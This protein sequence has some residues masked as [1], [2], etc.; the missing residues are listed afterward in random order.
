MR[1]KTTIVAALALLLASTAAAQTRPVLALYD[2][3]SD[4]ETFCAF[5]PT[6]VTPTANL[7][8]TAASATVTG[9]GAGTP[10][11]NVAVNDQLLIGFGTTNAMVRT[12]IARASASSI[13]VDSVSTFTSPST[14]T[15]F[16]YRNLRCSTDGTAGDFSVST[17]AGFTADFNIAQQNTT[18]GIDVR[19]QCRVGDINAGWKQVI[20][21]LTPPAVSGTYLT[22]TG[23]GGVAM[24]V[25]PSDHWDR[26]R[27]GLKLNST[28]D[29]GDLTTNREAISVTLQ[30]VNK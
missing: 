24:V 27:I 9:V 13:T 6:P 30:V 3:D 19:M 25:P 2:L 12:V 26:C 18:T 23:T 8:V 5:D 7:V 20:P 28:D 16:Q 11:T 22:F 1:L 29:G 21:A 15:P 10:F 4:T 17:F 14:G